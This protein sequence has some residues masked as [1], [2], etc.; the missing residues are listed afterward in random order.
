MSS[1]G[2][3]GGTQTTTTKLPSYVQPYATEFMSRA[4][5][6][7]KTPYQ[8]Y[9]GQQIAGLTPQHQQ[10][11]EGITQRAT[12]GNA[13]TNAGEGYLTDVISGKYLSPET[14]PYLQGQVQNAQRDVRTALGGQQRGAFGSTGMD[15]SLGKALGDATNDVYAQNYNLER[16]RQSQATALAPQYAQQDYTDLQ[17]LL[18]AGDIQRDFNQQNLSQAYSNWLDKKNYPL[19]QLDVLGNALRTT[20][21]GG[22]TSTSTGPGS[23]YN[24]LGGALGGAMTGAQLGSTFFPGIGTGI[25]AVGGALLGGLL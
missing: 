16:Q 24:R 17:Q 21:G 12:E 5:A 6:L 19:Q 23:S 18:G 25:G 22:G 3:S 15:Y 10:A 8:A 14:N 20:M 2:S 11:I 9:T 4:G 7:S 1:G 13:A